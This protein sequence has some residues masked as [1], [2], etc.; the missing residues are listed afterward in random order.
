MESSTIT[1]TFG[2][3]AE[4]HTGMQKI[5]KLAENGF[6]INE[7]NIAK[8][9]FK[10]KGTVC[11]LIILND[12]LPDKYKKS[13]NIDKAA[14]LVIRNGVNIILKNIDSQTKNPADQ[15]FDEQY[16]LNPDTK[17]FD[18]RRKKV[19]NKRARYNLC[20]A[21]EGQNANFEDKKGT[22]IAY[23]D[24][25]LTSK[26]RKELKKYIGNK[27]KNLEAEGN[28]YYDIKKCGIGFHGDSERKRVIAVRLG[29][30]IP[31]HYHWYTNS[32]P[33]G[34]RVEL[35]INHG[36]IYIMSE[37]ATGYD[38]KKRSKVTLRHAAGADKYL[39]IIKK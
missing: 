11:K 35:D 20:F 13:N 21:D 19:L 6:S 22:I 37:K 8:E 32:N 7:L 10:Q 39:R 9:K 5:G 15:M 25:P 26:L 18:T 14:V 1:I 29:A 27:A 2:D 31:L 28:Y 34:K 30:T 4:N 24:V 23:K 38:W 3:Q 33:I 12:Y 36:D 16:K 17:Y